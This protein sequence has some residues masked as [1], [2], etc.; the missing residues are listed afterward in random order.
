M[1]CLVQKL[2]PFPFKIRPLFWAPIWCRAAVLWLPTW[3]RT[4]FW[5]LLHYS[6]FWGAWISC[7]KSP[8]TPLYFNCFKFYCTFKI[9]WYIT[10]YTLYLCD[11]KYRATRQEQH[12]HVG[13]PKGEPKVVNCYLGLNQITF[14][15]IFIC[16]KG[17]RSSRWEVMFW[18]SSLNVHMSSCPSDR[19]NP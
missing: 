15:C 3:P 18:S 1:V 19:R 17:N 7:K 8:S 14:G 12:Y 11:K 6:I 2:Q 4:T 10:C 13:Q 5:G 9:W 16:S